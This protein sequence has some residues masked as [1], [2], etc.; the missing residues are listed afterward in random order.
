MKLIFAT[1]NQ[2]KLNEIKS[3]LPTNIDILSL[4]ELSFSQEIPEPYLTLE[5]NAATKANTIFNCFNEAC[6]SDDTGLFVPAINGAPGVHSAR[7]SG[8]NASASA[9]MNKLLKALEHI[10]DRKAY[11]QTTIALKTA[12]DLIYFTGKVYGS[13]ALSKKG[14][15]GFGYD[16]IFIP[17]NQSESFAELPLAIK[18]KIG[19]RG[20]AISA[21]IAYLNNL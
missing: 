6:F 2:N 20:K 10:T 1:H 13:I 17:E 3:Q 14:N 8:P 18:Q 21:L 11:F 9:N 7:Y 15:G 16:P 5:E 19:H 12:N 4:K